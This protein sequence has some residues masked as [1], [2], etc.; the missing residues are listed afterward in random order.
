MQV[1]VLNKSPIS[2]PLRPL[3]GYPAGTMCYARGT[4][5]KSFG[6]P[7][8]MLRDRGGGV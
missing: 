6:F 1:E 7:Y 3:R 2:N 8:G 5:P 4:S